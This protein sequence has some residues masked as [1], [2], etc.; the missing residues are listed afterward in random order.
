[1]SF[2]LGRP[3]GNPQ[4]PEFQRD[5]L[6]HALSLLEYP[7]GPVL[8]DYPHDATESTVEEYQIACPVNFA[9]PVEKLSDFED[10]LLQFRNEYSLMQTWFDRACEQ[11]NRSTTGVS[12]L[13][14]DEISDLLCDFISGKIQGTRMNGEPLSDI[15]RL[16][17][18]ELKACYLEGLSAQPGQPKGSTVLNNWFWG[19]T[20]AARIINEV[21]KRC[22]ECSEKDLVLLGKLLLVPRNQMHRFKK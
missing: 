5:V 13:T 14:P 3:L 11:R 8:D 16:A 2:P 15:L 18:E 10:L 6:K 1:M 9:P 12:G 4:D 17:S 19:D 7:K 21:R 22:L 20:Y